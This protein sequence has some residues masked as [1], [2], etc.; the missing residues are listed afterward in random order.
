[1]KARANNIALLVAAS[2]L[3]MTGVARAETAL[4]FATGVEYSS[5][6]Y[7]SEETTEVVAVPFAVRLTVDE[8][9]FRASSSYLD[10]TGP[11][12]ISEDGESGGSAFVRDSS[13]RGFGD[14]T[15]SLERAFRRIGGSHAYAAIT[16][17]V[18]LP[19]GDEEKGLGV[20]TVDYA[21]LGEVG[22]SNDLGGAYVSAGYRFVGERDNG[23]ERKDGMLAG[24]AAW[25]PVG[26]R[27]RV[28]AFGNWRQASVEGNDDPA[29]AG[30]YVSYR[31]AE[32]L[33]VTFTA[34]GGLSDASPAY[35]AGVR[36]NW[37]PGGL[38]N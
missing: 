35:I 4:S 6:E 17:R 18:R 7:G 13:E 1:M 38:N 36:F 30:A 11:A 16:A 25:L 28:G 5:G 9:T 37:L 24:I 3:T 26:N 31:M 33:R 8:W 20:G 10:V 32:R 21:L 29:T 23:P 27:M 22:I 14:T 19:T 12:D 15:L 34:T 2:F